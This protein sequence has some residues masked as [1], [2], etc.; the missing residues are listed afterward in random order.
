MVLFCWPEKKAFLCGQKV[1]TKQCYGAV[2]HNYA[3]PFGCYGCLRI[4]CDSLADLEKEKTDDDCRNFW[5]F[6]LWLGVA[7]PVT[8]ALILVYVVLHPTEGILV[9]PFQ[10]A[11]YIVLWAII[12]PCGHCLRKSRARAEDRRRKSRVHAEEAAKASKTRPPRYWTAAALALHL[13][14]NKV[15][16]RTVARFS[17]TTGAALVAAC[18]GDG[19]EA[20][21]V[22]ALMI[23]GVPPGFRERQAVRAALDQ[24]PRS[25]APTAKRWPTARACR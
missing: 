16:D 18:D 6:I 20:D 3:G 21:A 19:V 5:H 2:N 12:K 15:D 22:G 13:R 24:V 7:F 25:T 4:F 14:A 1:G 8:T 11:Y 9:A 10:I 17:R 23:R